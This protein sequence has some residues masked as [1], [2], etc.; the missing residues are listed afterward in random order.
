MGT[1]DMI[2]AERVS[3]VD[4]LGKLSDADWDKP[5]LCT[6]WSVR[7]VVAH[8]I[9]T[10]QMTPPAF[11]GKLIGSGFSFHL[12]NHHGY[13][14]FQSFAYGANYPLEK[15]VGLQLAIWELEYGLTD[16][17]FAPITQFTSRAQLNAIEVS[18]TS[19][20][21]AKTVSR[22]GSPSRRTKTRLPT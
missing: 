3:L 6:G 13:F 2:R 4:G 20:T 14:P 15:A 1:W 21:E 10:A 19:R 16:S 7:E 5:S 12:Y 11:F 8:L 17:S 9:V 18:E 22:S